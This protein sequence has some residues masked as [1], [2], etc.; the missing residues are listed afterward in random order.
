MHGPLF[1]IQILLYFIV[2]V[3]M[4]IKDIK[5]FVHSDTFAADGI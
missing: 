2:S 3:N 1:L 4:F 5:I